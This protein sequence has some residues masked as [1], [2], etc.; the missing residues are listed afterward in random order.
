M[1]DV[2][3]VIPTRNRATLLRSAIG[4]ALRCDPAPSEVLIVDC[5]STDDTREVVKSFRDDVKLIERRLPNV[6]SAR[7]VG[8]AATRSPYIGF[9]DS[10]DEALPGKTG[11]LAAALDAAPAT[12]LVHGAIEIITEEGGYLPSETA[13]NAESRVKA[14]KAGTSYPALADFCSMYTSAT[15]IRRSA[16]EHAGGYDESLDVYEDWDLYLRLSLI[17]SLLYE[18][19]PAARYRVWSGNVPWDRTARGV[20]EVARKH[21]DM[22]DAVPSDQQR[23]SKAAFHRRLAGSLYTLV[24]LREARHEARAALWLSPRRAV[25]SPE[26]RRALV[27]SLLPVSSLDRRRPPRSST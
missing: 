21:L 19:I 25:A 18:D 8:F 24:E 10:D 14:R 15:L 27:R 6:A 16:L 1:T 13:R 23:V 3:I 20:V 5:G 4:S 12:V 17:G 7:N 9:L 11:E 22:L 2:A 26:V